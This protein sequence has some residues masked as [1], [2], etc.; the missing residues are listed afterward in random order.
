MSVGCLWVNYDQFNTLVDVSVTQSLTLPL[1]LNTTA[2]DA[3][4]AS[5]PKRRIFRPSRLDRPKKVG[6]RHS[7]TKSEDTLGVGVS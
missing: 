2:D 7:I 4:T 6:E 3:R 5:I 1:H